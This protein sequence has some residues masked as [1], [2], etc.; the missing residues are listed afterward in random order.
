MITDSVLLGADSEVVHAD[1]LSEM[2]IA[3]LLIKNPR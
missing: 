2:A 1:V 3:K